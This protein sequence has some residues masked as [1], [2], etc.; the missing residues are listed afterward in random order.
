[1]IILF[2]IECGGHWIPFNTLFDEKELKE[3][4]PQE[5]FSAVA[6]DNLPSG[7]ISILFPDGSRWDSVQRAWTYFLGGKDFM[8]F[9]MDYVSNYL[10]DDRGYFYWRDQGPGWRTR[11]EVQEAYKNF[12]EETQ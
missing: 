8:E 7:F 11:E 10:K 3:I 12:E 9:W 5:L 6:G 1:M 4:L 2:T